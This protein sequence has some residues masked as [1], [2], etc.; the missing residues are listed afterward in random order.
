VLGAGSVNNQG[1]RYRYVKGHRPGDVDIAGIPA[2]LVMQLRRDAQERTD[3]AAPP[4]VE[5]SISGSYALAALQREAEAVRNAPKGTRN[6]RLNDSA[7]SIGQLVAAG[8]IDL[9][10]VKSA[11]TS[12]AE[13]VGLEPDEIRATLESGL[14]G[15][16]KKPRV[17]KKTSQ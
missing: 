2:W 3:P 8:S 9:S 15:G 6:N 10:E 7:F 12:A 16:R 5:S 11:L 14:R 4:C 17:R 13:A 1:A